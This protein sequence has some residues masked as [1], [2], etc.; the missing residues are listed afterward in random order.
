LSTFE[1]YPAIDLRGGRVVRLRQG[2][3]ARE[4]AYATDPVAVATAFADQGARWVHVVDLD[5]ARTGEPEQT[6]LV[7]R[8]VAAL[9]GRVQV[10]VA[11]GLR[12][13][14]AVEEAL[15]AGAARVVVGTAALR[16]PR[17]VTRLIAAHGPERIAVALDVREGRA[18]GEGW[19]AGAE[20]PSVDRAVR[21]LTS[22]GAR[23]FAVTAIERDGLLAGPDLQLLARL[24]AAGVGIVASG[25]IASLADLEAV[26][27]A[28]CAGAIVG[29]ALYE[30]RIDL[31]A[32]LAATTS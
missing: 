18:I 1:L 30:G 11:G 3:F 12:T 22:A 10:Q 6:A 19:R 15:S 2:D 23:I 25:G 24:A 9:A 31:R 13:S 16:D 5:G 8:I 26:R 21:S 29:R 27:R 32:A 4:T 28:G 14:G 20:G 7:A 17:L